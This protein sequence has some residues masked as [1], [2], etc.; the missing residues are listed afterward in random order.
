MRE[1][2]RIKPFLAYIEREWEKNSDL[3]FGQI[4]I[5]LGLVENDFKTWNAEM[6]DYN[7]PHEVMREIISW[8]KYQGHCMNKIGGLL[9]E[10]PMHQ[11][12]LIKDL[13]TKHINAILRTQKHIKGLKIEKILE[14]E[15]KYRKKNKEDKTWVGP[16]F[17]E[18]SYEKK[19]PTY[20]V[21]CSSKCQATECDCICHDKMRK[22]YEK[23]NKRRKTTSRRIKR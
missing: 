16:F 3:R 8:G 10:I 1:I 15:L 21:G 20:C 22:H 17:G 12:I 7:L 13:E 18:S 19:E 4:L 6:E 14:D 11:P 23:K 2:K 9:V 5:N